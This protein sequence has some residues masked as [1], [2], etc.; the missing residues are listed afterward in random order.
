MDEMNLRDDITAL[1][2]ITDPVDPRLNIFACVGARLAR[3]EE[4]QG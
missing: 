3:R 1:G 2:L 4:A